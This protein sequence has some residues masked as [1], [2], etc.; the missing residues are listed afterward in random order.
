MGSRGMNESI[1]FVE[2][3]EALGMVLS[4]R[5]SSEGYVVEVA[6]DGITG[7][8]KATSQHFDVMILDIML[9]GRNG[10]DL[11]RDIRLA[12]VD[13]PILLL[14]A[15]DAIADKVVGLK[16]GADDY[17]T[18]PFDMRE[19]VTRIEAL[20]RRCTAPIG[21][22]VYVVGTIRVDF[23]AREI[24][25]KGTPVRLSAMEFRLLRYL[26]QHPGIG[27]SREKI[28]REVW[29]HHQVTSSRTLDVHVASL[30]HKLEADPARPELIV[31][32][33]NFGYM[34]TGQQGLTSEIAVKEA[35]G[36]GPSNIGPGF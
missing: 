21:I 30:R 14:T 35:A 25:R 2:D 19:L 27:L 23:S 32:V 6:R 10:L 20:L 5:L 31:T 9:P 18:K 29:G 11:C 34:Y 1:L 22:S 7:F 24:T 28:L 36:A 13:T 26:L 8:H 4:D 17:V 16:L 15:R 12:G 3:E 33:K